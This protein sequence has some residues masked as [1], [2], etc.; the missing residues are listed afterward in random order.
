MLT[1]VQHFIQRDI[2]RSLSRHGSQ[3]FSE[4]RPDGIANNLF[5]YHLKQLI[6]NGIVERKNEHYG[7]TA[8]GI[9]YVSLATRTN[10]DIL[11]SPK[12][13]CLLI[14]ENDSGNFIMH[15]RNAS[16]FVGQYTFPGGS[17]FYGE[18]L[19]EL[20][21]RQLIEKVGLQIQ[22]THKGIANIR[23]QHGSNVWSHNYAHIYYT[24]VDGS[25]RIRSKDARFTPAWI[26]ISEVDD[27]RLMPDI[28]EI[29]GATKDNKEFFYLEIT[30]HSYID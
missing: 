26:N 6:N 16:P 18:S 5:G 25:P 27:E 19:G 22:L 9:Q 12:I 4:L 3:S 15:T 17:L 24:K 14:I 21:Q 8:A 10:I 7:L 13:F 29:L 2:L 1:V 28:R 11:P 20:T 23:H 30:Q